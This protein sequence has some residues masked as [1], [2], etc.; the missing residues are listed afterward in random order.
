M[1]FDLPFGR[2]FPVETAELRLDQRPHEM[3]LAAGAAIDANWLREKAA[4]PEIHD[5][6]IALFSKLTWRDGALRGTCH[7]TR[8]ATF[9]YWRAGGMR[10][11][12]AHLYA[13]AVLTAN[14]GRLVAVRMGGH[15]L[16]AGRVYFAAGSLEP[17]D[18]PG[19][20][21]DLDANMRRE[22]LEET[23]LDLKDFRA[24]PTMHALSLENGTVVF[25]RYVAPHSAEELA[26]R[27]AAHVAAESEP[28]ITGAVVIDGPKPAGLNLSVQMPGI[29]KWHFAT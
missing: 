24:E 16:N 19:E 27:I 3:E 15:T 12:A 9:L 8:Y 29:L 7:I 10:D 20:T 26:R 22:V 17:E 5:G 25:R 18:F 13:H 2:V 11:R 6:R 4:R 23:G 21:A 1:E 28:E 14:D